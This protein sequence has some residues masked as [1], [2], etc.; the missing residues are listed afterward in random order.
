[1]GIFLDQGSNPCALHWRADSLPLD[2]QG[3][4]VDPE[5]GWVVDGDEGHGGMATRTVCVKP[6]APARETQGPLWL[7]SQATDKDIRKDRRPQVIERR[8]AS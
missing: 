4:P 7:R 5:L 6:V 2:H 1:M 3:S 8:Q